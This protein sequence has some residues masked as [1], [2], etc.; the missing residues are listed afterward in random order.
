MINSFKTDTF[1]RRFCGEKSV[2]LLIT[3]AISVIFGCAWMLTPYLAK[4]SAER[5][6]WSRLPGGIL[7]FW[8]VFAALVLVVLLARKVR[9]KH[10]LSAGGE[11]FFAVV[12]FVANLLTGL[13]FLAV[14]YPGTGNYDTLAIMRNEFFMARQHPTMYIAFVCALKAIV[15][16][17]GGR[18]EELFLANSLLTILL[19]SW[20]YVE[21][22]CFLKRTGVPVWV[23]LLIALF[24]TLCP[25][26]N[27]YKVTFLKDVP[28]SLLLMLWVPVLYET[29]A[30]GGGNLKKPSVWIKVCL[31]LVL[32]LMRG[33]GLYV[34]VFVLACMLLVARKMWKQ[35]LVYTLVLV[36]ATSGIGVVEDFLEV[37][38]LFKETVG[39]PLQQMAAVVC[40]DGEL[41]EAQAEFIDQVLPLEFIREKYDPYNSVPLKWGGS[42]I[43][44]DFLYEHKADFLKVWAELLVPNFRT[45]VKSYLQ[46][47]YGFWS[48]GEALGSYRYT[49]LY[50]KAYDEWITRNEIDMKTVLPADLQMTLE[51]LGN[52]WIQVPGE[53]VCFWA[54]ILLVLVLMYFTDWK[55]FL[56]SAP[57]LAGVLTVFIST[58]IAYSWRYILFIPLFIPVVVGLLLK[59]DDPATAPTE[60]E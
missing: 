47:T 4:G 40:T 46:S 13:L 11:R 28:F 20:V 32:S 59:Q 50:E 33:N 27:L 55:M 39:V 54:M 49:A 17:L 7:L 18:Y 24:Y 35:I 26:F 6:N 48:L 53:G 44:D 29:W 8:G 23:R 3:A 14:F 25:I 45:Y 12:F 19:T 30:T 9:C 34:S 52:Q 15:F 21:M 57:M 41:T 42:P 31:Y 58:P 36:M 2:V 51:S 37:R 1:F 22:L 16:T 43:D 5:L 38:H 56:V 10:E 60:E